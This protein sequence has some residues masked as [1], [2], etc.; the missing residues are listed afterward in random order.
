MKKI[1]ALSVL[2]VGI[3]AHA[4]PNLTGEWTCKD[5]EGEQWTESI[6]TTGNRYD[7][8]YDKGTENEKKDQVIADGRKIKQSPM[9]DGYVVTLFNKMAEKTVNMLPEDKQAMFIVATK[10][11]NGK[12][13]DTFHGESTV[14]CQ[15]NSLKAHFTFDG[16]LSLPLVVTAEGKGSGNLADVLN[17]KERRGTMKIVG[18]I[19]AKP[20]SL[21]I[22]KDIPA[23]TDKIDSTLTSHCVKK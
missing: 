15:G 16:G 10:A 20:A 3:Q 6:V 17:G 8:I 22:Y 7:I 18:T 19:T 13:Q 4:C 23:K 12:V 11:F 9:V 2:A 14:T 21:K 5:S 1:I